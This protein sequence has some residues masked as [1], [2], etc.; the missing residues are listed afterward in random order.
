M[1]TEIGP[2][3][4]NIYIGQL[5]SKRLSNKLIE[6]IR[7]LEPNEPSGDSNK[8]K[9]ATYPISESV[10]VG[11][12]RLPSILRSMYSRLTN[13]YFLKTGA[14]LNVPDFPNQSFTIKC[15]ASGQSHEVHTDG[16]QINGSYGIGRILHSSAIC[17][18]D[19]Y[20]G[21]WTQFYL[22]GTMQNPNIDIEVKLGAGQALIFN[23]D[24]NY[25]GISEVTSG[26]RFSLIQF[27]RE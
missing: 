7:L 1:L 20:K 2:K 6:S 18:N 15:Q 17:L 16:G 11:G 19:D 23:A 27:W 24:L 25:H 22:T 26:S 9:F 12:I 21:G 3:G 5:I 13:E 8:N 10:Y 14:M 4:S